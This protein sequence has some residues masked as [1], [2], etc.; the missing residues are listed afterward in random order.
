MLA[1][2]FQW[3]WRY[4][5]LA[6]ASVSIALHMWIR[7]SESPVWY[8]IPLW[9]RIMLPPSSTH[10][11]KNLLPP[12]LFYLGHA[13]P[14]FCR[15]FGKQILLM[16]RCGYPNGKFSTPS[17]GASCA[18]RI[19]APLPMLCPPFQQTY[20]P[21]CAFIWLSQWFGLT[22]Q[23]CSVQHQKQL[24]TLLMDTLLNPP[25]PLKSTLPQQAP[26]RW[27]HTQPPPPPGS[28]MWMFIWT[29]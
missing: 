28:S 26:T 16:S 11:P 14:G 15:I 21:Y 9:H 7:Q 17:T 2:F 24:R 4:L 8:V 13:F 6:A 3:T 20:Q 23:I 10:I 19:S 27:L 25:E 5:F 12:T 18:R 29:I 1:S 22:L